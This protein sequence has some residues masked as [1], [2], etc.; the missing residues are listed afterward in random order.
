MTTDTPKSLRERVAASANPQAVA[1]AE[2]A[3]NR[4]YVVDNYWPR[5]KGPK[6]F[7]AKI[8]IRE[9][10]EIRTS[11][12][13]DPREVMVVDIDP[14]GAEIY[15]TNP[16][17]PSAMAFDVGLPEVGKS[18][19]RNSEIV[20]TA[21][22]AQKTD[23]GK[24]IRDYF[25][26]DGKVVEMVGDVLIIKKKNDYDTRIFF[27]DV[28]FVGGDNGLNIPLVEAVPPEAE[29][30]VKLA[31]WAI[32]KTKAQCNV[33]GL[34]RACKDLGIDKDSGL[35]GLIMSDEG[36]FLPYASDQGLILINEDGSITD[37]TT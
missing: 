1:A 14:D 30:V 9:E 20:M 8:H 7:R 35:K 13:Y 34:L 12:N 5:T 18:A 2:E 28:T 15:V 21:E 32:G 33:S 17:N 27:Y 25:D 16:N 10:T 22:S 36:G 3:R 23:G 31:T 29:S 6:H 24:T 37:P 19:A 26:L 4:Q 11:Q